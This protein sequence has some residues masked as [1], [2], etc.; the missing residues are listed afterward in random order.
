M[1]G[2]CKREHFGLGHLLFDLSVIFE[3]L[4]RDLIVGIVLVTAA[5]D[6]AKGSASN[7]FAE[8]V[9]PDLCDDQFGDSL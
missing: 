4:D 6:G 5:I 2:C 9:L 3:H 8:D 7:L 1:L